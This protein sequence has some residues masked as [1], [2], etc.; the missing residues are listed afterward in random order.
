M[1]DDAVTIASNVD[2]K[3]LR[4]INNFTKES[5]KTFKG[6]WFGDYET[7]LGDSE[8]PWL[9]PI[10]WELG[11]DARFDGLTVFTLESHTKSDAGDIGHFTSL[12]P[13]GKCLF[14]ILVELDREQFQQKP[15]QKELKIFTQVQNQTY[16][17]I[18]KAGFKF[19]SEGVWFLPL[20]L[21]DNQVV[22]NYLSDNLVD[23]FVPIT[24]ALKKLQEVHPHFVSIIEDAKK[25]FGGLALEDETEK[26]N[27]IDQ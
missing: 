2:E 24:D 22:E 23:A 14:G 21:D 1:L 4:E 11:D 16:P 10:K 3:V 19:Y 27:S 26:L 13:T 12:F 5:V 18:E 25:A 15:K 17:A 8:F 20:S 6:Q 9:S 7:D